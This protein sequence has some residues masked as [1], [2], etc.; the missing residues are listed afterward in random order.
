MNK[1]M[2]KLTT[3]YISIIAA[4]VSLLAAACTPM[5]K[6]AQKV[7]IL[8]PLYPDYADVA[9][10]CNI[11][12]LNFLLRDDDIE[13]TC[14]MAD[15]RVISS[16][17]D[18][19]VRIDLADWRN[20]MS[21]SVGSDVSV[22]VFAMK[23]GQWTEYRP[24]TWTVVADSIDAYLTYRLIEPDYEV[25]H[26]LEI[27]ERCLENFDTRPISTYKLTGD[28]C[29]NC[30]AYGGARRDRSMFYVRGEGGGALFNDNGRLRKLNLKAD[31]MASGSVYFGISPSVRYVTFSTNVIIPA[32]HSMPSKRLEVFDTK[33]DVYV[34]DLQTHR[35]LTSPLLTDSTTFET[36]PTFSPDGRYI[37]YCGAPAA[38]S[39]EGLQYVLCRIAFDEETGRL[40]DRVDTIIGANGPIEGKTSIC[41]PRVSP[42]GRFILYTVAS[43]GTFPIWHPEADLQMMNLQTG[44]VDTLA[45]VNSHKSDTYHSW[46]A[47]SRWFTFASKRDDG[48]YGKPYFCYV[49]TAGVAHKP[50][51]LP[52]ENPRHYDYFLK[53]YNA[54]ELGPAPV[55]FSAQ[56]VVRAMG[57]EAENF[58]Y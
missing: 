30:H 18:N 4:L 33:S 8:P 3:R 14:V 2:T 21:E 57:R 27:E 31:G 15:G 51:A 53:S 29:M 39:I 25:W 35:I 28:K 1:L 54:P 49:D 44:D 38:T 23:N 20:L 58:T 37:Y 55:P 40:G 12:P 48:L 36:F 16:E 46:S 19:T 42:D 34:A 45:I 52:Q 22:S 32:F 13:A 50:F 5:P 6:D 56:D 7:D 43:Y 41:H 17:R 10:P 11:A 9:I 24:F 26:N 47:N